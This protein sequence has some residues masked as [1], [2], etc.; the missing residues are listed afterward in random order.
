MTPRRRNPE[1][2]DL[3]KWL[4]KVGRGGYEYT[5]PTDKKRFYMGR[6]REYAIHTAKGLNA[7][8][9]PQL[10]TKRV[11]G[12]GLSLDDFLDSHFETIMAERELAEITKVD[13]RQKLVH[14]RQAFGPDTPDQ[15]TVRTIADF[16]DGYPKTQ[17]NRYRA[18]LSIIWRYAVAKGWAS[19]NPVAETIP[20]KERV[21]RKRLTLADYRAIWTQ[22]TSEQRNAF[23]LAL[24]T[25][26]ARSTLVNIRRQDFKDGVLKV[27]RSK[28]GV[29][30]KIHVTRQLQAV[31][32]RCR[33]DGVF[34][35]WLLHRPG[36][37]RRRQMVGQKLRPETLSRWF[38]DARDKTYLYDDLPTLECPSFHEIRSLGAH[39]MEQAGIDKAIIQALLG[40][41]EAKIT[42]LYLDRHEQRWIEVTGGPEL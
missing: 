1:N 5:R 19:H 31:I 11:L 23:D 3:P 34:S 24:Y 32:D 7:I 20:K 14:I 40:H 4:N 8:Y 25:L 39:L 36:G 10:L 9:I 12:R 15:Q 33:S 2:E 30:I 37:S 38:Q 18:L 27:S 26:Q 21:K 17:S 42:E 29:R 41:K 28:T 22:G 13:Y 6:D 16:L 35:H